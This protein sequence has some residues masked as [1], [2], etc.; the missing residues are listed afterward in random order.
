MKIFSIPF[1]NHQAKGLVQDSW[2]TTIL[3]TTDRMVAIRELSKGCFILG[4]LWLSASS[5]FEKDPS[6]PRRFTV[7]AGFIWGVSY[8]LASKLETV[9]TNMIKELIEDRQSLWN[10]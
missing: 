7:L 3:Q 1:Y 5:F 2:Q 4:T 8:F 6:M 10:Q 9:A